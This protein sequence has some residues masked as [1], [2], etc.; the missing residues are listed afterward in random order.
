MPL[1][2]GLLPNAVSGATPDR[3]ILGP[4]RFALATV[5]L[6]LVLTHIAGLRLTELRR[7]Q[8]VFPLDAWWF[9]PLWI[10]AILPELKR[11]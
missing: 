4:E 2:I 9:T 6:F 3:P 5:V 1:G 7:R 8:C 11:N 10:Y